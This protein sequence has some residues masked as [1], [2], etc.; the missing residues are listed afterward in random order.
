MTK[1]F[2]LRGW[3]SSL[4]EEERRLEGRCGR[5]SKIPN[6]QSNRA[7]GLTLVTRDGVEARILACC[8]CRRDQKIHPNGL[9]GCRFYV[10]GDGS[11]SSTC[12]RPAS[13]R[14]G[15]RNKCIGVPANTEGLV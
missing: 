10:E 12:N 9:V 5:K 3:C 2:L 4:A 14:V 1:Q 11:Q 8:S 15:K 13:R 7:G 6:S